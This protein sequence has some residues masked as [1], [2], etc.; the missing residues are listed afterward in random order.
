MHDVKSSLV[1]LWQIFVSCWNARKWWV[2]LNLS[3]FYAIKPIKHTYRKSHSCTWTLVLL[4][5][6]LQTLLLHCLPLTWALLEFFLVHQPSS[7]W[8]SILPLWFC[9]LKSTAFCM[10][11][12][13]QPIPLLGFLF[14]FAVMEIIWVLHHVIQLASN[15]APAW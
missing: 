6:H 15:F 3:I 13:M 14:Y 7:L 2:F 1:N 9:Q 11:L 10:N 12:F 5:S 4:S 8:S